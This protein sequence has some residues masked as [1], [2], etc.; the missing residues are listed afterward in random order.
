[1]GKLKQEL[2]NNINE[3]NGYTENAE[4]L[5]QKGWKQISDLSEG[6]VIVTLNKLT[7]EAEFKP[8][9]KIL[10]REHNGIIAHIKGKK[11]D[12]YLTIDCKYPVLT[13]RTKNFS[14]FILARD[15]IELKIKDITHVFIP[16]NPDA[17]GYVTLEKISLFN[18]NLTANIENY[19][20]KVYLINVEN[21]IWYVRQNGL[22]H[23]ACTLE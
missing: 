20:G 3:F 10:V 12:D 1:M 7:L 14:K 15:M 17:Y 13:N 6:E 19:I 21:D 2:D 8:I 9:N 23:W 11:I 5:T 16:K 4:V 22:S 18:K